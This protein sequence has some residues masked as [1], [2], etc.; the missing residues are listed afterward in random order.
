MKRFVFSL[1]TVKRLRADAEHDAQAALGRAMAAH[2]AAEAAREA[3]RRTLALAEE[4]LV[5]PTGPAHALVQADRERQAAILRLGAAEA[6]R[7][8]ARRTVDTSRL[9]L[10]TASRALEVLE[11]LEERRREA[12]R[13]AALREEEAVVQEITEARAA[14]R[15]RKAA[16]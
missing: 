5:A 8:A 2:R 16:L 6:G 4:Q 3:R 1:E 13:A 11:R 7:N 12:H 14:R 10:A 9:D 15:A